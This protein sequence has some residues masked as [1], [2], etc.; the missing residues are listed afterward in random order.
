MGL[1][2]DEGDSFPVRMSCDPATETCQAKC[3]D[4]ET[5]VFSR[6]VFWNGAEDMEMGGHSG[7]FAANNWDG[8]F[9]CVDHKRLGSATFTK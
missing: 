7:S 9:T 3:V 8:T 6:K 5:G 4:P 2:G 1:F